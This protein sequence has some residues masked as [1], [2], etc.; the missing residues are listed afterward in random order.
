MSGEPMIHDAYPAAR[1]GSRRLRFLGA[2]LASLVFAG[3]LAMPMAAQAQGSFQNFLSEL[4]PAAQKRGVSKSVFNAAFANV[5]PDPKVMD[6][7]RR[8]AEFTETSG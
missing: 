4:W 6:S 5:A 7:T 1:S 8:Q 2:I 3:G